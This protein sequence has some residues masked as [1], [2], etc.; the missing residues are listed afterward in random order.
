MREFGS[1]HAQGAFQI[2]FGGAMLPR[3]HE[4][5]V[6]GRVLGLAIVLALAT[7][8]LVGMVPAFKLS[9][10][11]GL[12]ALSYRGAG[13]QGGE[14][15]GDMR[16]RDVLIVGQVAMATMLLVGATLVINSFGRLS[17]VDPGWNA[18]GVLTFYLVMPQE[19]STARK[20]ELIERM[21]DEL[22]A[23]PRVQS[24]GFTYAGPLLGLV[25]TLRYVRPAGTHAGRDARQPG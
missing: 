23:L 15:R 5:V 2:S 25:D 22:R 7:A 17:H 11:D 24:A 14:T 13:G 6:D 21:I 4:I 19:Y 12:H 1:P 18:R 3:L 20:A 9:H 8:L 16:L 10:A